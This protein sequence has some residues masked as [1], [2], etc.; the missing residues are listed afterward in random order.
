LEKGKKKG[1]LDNK[2]RRNLPG[3][4]PMTQAYSDDFD[5][6]VL[7]EGAPPLHGYRGPQ[8]DTSTA[9]I[10]AG[11]S[12]AISREAGARGTTIAKRAG[13]KLGWDLYT[14]DMM[15]YIVQNAPAQNEVEEKLPAGAMEW[16]QA[17]L[18]D[19]IKS[20][21]LSVNPTVQALARLVLMLGTHGNVVLVGRGAGFLLPQHSTL[22][23]RLIA[24]LADR[25]AYTSQWLR[26]TEEE[27]ADQ[28]HKR[29]HRRT[30]FLTTYFHRKPNDVHGYD[31]MLNTSLL[32]EEHCADLVVAAAKAKMS[33]VFGID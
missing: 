12:I 17:Q 10:P 18:L 20:Q 4:Y 31:M 22:H 29:D 24:P 15:D 1:M 9:R 8:D 2:D 33:A 7:E 6:P 30:D 26:L 21:H 13:E 25:I 3:I 27:A 32:G 23:V 14:Q 28:V 11:L 19:L 5:L 16:T